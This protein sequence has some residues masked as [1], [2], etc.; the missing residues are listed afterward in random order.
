MQQTSLDRWIKKKFVYVYEIH[1][2]LVPKGIMRN[3][4]L[5]ETKKIKDRRRSPW[6]KIFVFA[7]EESYDEAIRRFQAEAISYET[8]IKPKKKWW[9]RY[10]DPPSKSSVTYNIFWTIV[11][12]AISVMVMFMAPLEWIK[13]IVVTLIMS[14]V[15]RP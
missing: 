8:K 5:V 1:S 11:K 6:K 12:G 10:L 7:S 2:N 13:G 9:V 14:V 15:R 4:K 3:Y